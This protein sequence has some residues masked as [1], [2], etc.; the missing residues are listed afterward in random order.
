MTLET[1]P[2]KLREQIEEVCESMS[3]RSQEKGLELIIDVSH[4]EVDTVVGDSA[5]LRQVLTNLLGNAL[6][7]TEKGEVIVAASLH[8]NGRNW[9]LN[10]HVRDTC[11]AKLLSRA[12]PYSM[13]PSHHMSSTLAA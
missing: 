9:Q 8:N 3:L 4:I 11:T 12:A 13:M 6:K 7:F 10:C 2:F 1:Q 5:R